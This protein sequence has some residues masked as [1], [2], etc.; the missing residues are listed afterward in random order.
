VSFELFQLLPAIYR[1]RDAQIAQTLTLLTPAEQAQLAALQALPPPLLPDQEAQLAELTAKAARGP[2]ESLLLL[3]QEQV[4]AVAYDIEQLYDDQFIET[5]APW[6]IPYIG[7]L[8]GYQPVHGIAPAVDDP[9]AEVANTISLRR[10]KGTIL[11][12]EQLARDVTGW[13]AHAVEFFEVL[14]TTQYMNHVRL[15]NHYAPDLRRWQ[16]RV[17]MNTGF[18]RTAHKV[19]VRR[20]ASGR[21]RYDIQNVGVFLWSLGAYGVTGADAVP[22]KPTPP[23]P[24]AP[25][26]Y[27][28]DSLGR[29]VPLFHRAAPQGEE[30]TAP[31][32]PVNVPDRLLRRVL[33]DD[34]RKGVGA[35]YYGPGASLSISVGGKLLEPYEIRV[36]D[37][38]GADGSWANVEIAHGKYSALVDPELGRIALKPS[39]AGTA[40]APRTVKV[41]Y[42][43]GFNADMGGG[44]YTRGDFAVVDPAWVVPLPSDQTGVLDLGAAI[45][46]AVSQFA[47]SGAVAI[48]ITG[49]QPFT[50]TGP[51]TIDLPANATLEIRAA[52]GSRPTLLLA[53][54][55][56]MSGD[57]ASKLL[58]NGLI[59][60]AGQGFAAGS[61]APKGLVHVPPVRPA[62]MPNLLSQVTL[63][64]CTLVPGWSLDTDGRPQHAD[65]PA[66]YAEPAGVSVVATRSILGPLRAPELA[67]VAL[68]DSIVDATEVTGVAY[69][70]LDGE[71]GGGALTLEACTVI[72]KVH[73]SLLSL[74]SDSIL[75]GALAKADASPWVSALVADREQQGCVRFSFIPYNAV[76]PRQYEC[77]S[78]ALASPQPYF[79]SLRYGH[80]AY[81]KVLADTDD[82]IRR[83]ASDGGE[84]GAFH[85]LLAPQRET[86]LLVR[87]QEYLPVGLESGLVYQ[88]TR[89]ERPHR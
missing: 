78:R 72:G 4:A 30:I 17:Y 37:L 83:G 62:N 24:T 14:G 23:T 61:P 42:C 52:R 44:E 41:S 74:V 65:S 22:A 3:V 29:D 84:M 6:V 70:A 15:G 20:I 40:A 53:D 66:L 2:L 69:A 77:V 18:D 39:I 25:I 81:C 48:E 73:A 36:A 27:R 86:D 38:S 45:T 51:L 67:T 75:W 89:N 47:L 50:V 21:G 12:I 68:S 28:F 60:A 16:P 79:G 64:D 33:C 49:S 46:Y 31:A 13:R 43:Y 19:D 71:S 57:A 85:S 1:L 9:R 10:R 54:E 80:P 26:C 5:C 56:A 63:T 7:D 8:I 34:L 58:L 32:G 55:L 59:I 82:S 76:T 35:S 11:V 88:L 87:L